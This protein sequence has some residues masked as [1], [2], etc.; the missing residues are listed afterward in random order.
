MTA[1]EF[2]SLLRIV[3]NVVYVLALVFVMSNFKCGHKTVVTAY[4]LVLAVSASFNGGMYLLFGR[5]RMMQVFAVSI[6]VPCLIALL[7]LTRDR[8]P[9]LM[10]NFFT[11]VNALYLV[12]VIGLSISRN[13]ILWLDILIRSAL[14]SVILYL[15]SRYF[16][17]PYHF[18]AENMTKGWWAISVIPFLFFFLVMFLGL[19]PKVNNDNFPAVLILYVI[20]GFVYVVIYQVFQNTYTRI[21]QKER[22]RM[23]EMQVAM[24]KQN[25]SRIQFLRHDTRHYINSIAAFLK[26]GKTEEALRFIEQFDEVAL[27]ERPVRWCENDM[28]NA[29]LVYYLNLA[30]EEQI[31]VEARLDLP[32]EL[33]VTEVELVSVL[34]NAIENAVNACRKQPAGEPRRLIL[35]AVSSPQLAIE[36]SN[37]YAGKV[38]FGADGLPICAEKGHGIG[39]R[40]IAAF[41]KRHGAYYSFSVTDGLFCVRLMLAPSVAGKQKAKAAS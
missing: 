32:G 3:V 1:L 31:S 12:S 8:F 18:L 6:A 26:Q 5:E 37:T 15:F 10:F 29:A 23:L 19:Y 4:V 40:S 25:E 36:I 14:Y 27:R 30:Q 33:P 38:K 9:E 13:E 7:T 21:R 28:L 11:A 35:S 22:S 34:S 39:T 24:H 41:A 17:A 2:W 20:L 16:S